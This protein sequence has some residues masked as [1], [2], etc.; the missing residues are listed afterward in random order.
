MFQLATGRDTQGRVKC[1]AAV[2]LSHEVQD[3]LLSCYWPVATNMGLDTQGHR[4]EFKCSELLLGF[5]FVV[6]ID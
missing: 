2:V 6:M 4:P 1:K 3:P 5:H